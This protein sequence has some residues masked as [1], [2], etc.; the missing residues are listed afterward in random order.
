[1]F[2]RTNLIKCTKWPQSKLNITTP[3]V[4]H[5]NIKGVPGSQISPFFDLDFRDKCT[6]LLQNDLYYYKVKDAPYILLLY[7]S[8][9][10][11]SASLH[12]QQLSSYMP[13]G[14]KLTGLLKLKIDN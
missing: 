12:N 8:P 7:R 1:M 11:Q 14:E 2:H 9:N 13:S 10:L 5:I 3:K 6:K 4:P